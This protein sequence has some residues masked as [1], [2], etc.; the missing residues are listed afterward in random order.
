MM[1]VAKLVNKTLPGLVVKAGTTAAEVSSK[2]LFLTMFENIGKTLNFGGRVIAGSSNAATTLM[3][4]EVSANLSKDKLAALLAV[5]AGIGVTAKAA[6]DTVKHVRTS[7]L[8]QSRSGGYMTDSK[9]NAT[10]RNVAIATGGVGLIAASQGV[11]TI[12]GDSLLKANA[13]SP[14]G[15]LLKTVGTGMQKT[16]GAV[17]T[18]TSAMGDAIKPGLGKITGAPLFLMLGGLVAHWAINE[19]KLKMP[20]GNSM[21]NAMGW[22]GSKNFLVTDRTDPNFL[23]P[24]GRSGLM[25]KINKDN[26]NGLGRAAPTSEF[27]ELAVT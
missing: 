3:R 12:A 27:W 19:V 18:V 21:F 13:A 14:T 16:L 1:N 10:L 17:T 8:I 6:S 5:A 7:C 2:G 26:E 22:G 23:Q 4:T 20:Q 25:D 9:T 15:A 24:I 11:T